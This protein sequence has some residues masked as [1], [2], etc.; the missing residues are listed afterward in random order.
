MSNE[1]YFYFDD[2]GQPGLNR[3]LKWHIAATVYTN[4]QET[5]FDTY[6]AIKKELLKIK[7]TRDHRELKG[8]DMLSQE[9]EVVLNALKNS[10]LNLVASRFDTSSAPQNIVKNNNAKFADTGIVLDSTGLEARH[11]AFLAWS[12][13]E[14]IK[15]SLSK[16]ILHYDGKKFEENKELKQELRTHLERQLGKI[17]FEVYTP[18]SK[19]CEGV[20]L[21]DV[22]AN[23][24]Y[25]ALN[26]KDTLF[27]ILK[28]KAV[29]A[30]MKIGEKQKP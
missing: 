5:I 24:Q 21:A 14:P 11:F 15:G 19:E 18:D 30:E 2:S 9:R 23:A 25:R 28:G 26:K 29:T 16:V 22:L 8:T 17:P 3:G 13:I 4:T 7:P 1:L 12:I 10:S 20:Q 27:E 6:S